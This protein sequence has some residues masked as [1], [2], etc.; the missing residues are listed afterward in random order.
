MPERFSRPKVSEPKF[1]RMMAP[2]TMSLR[3]T[4]CYTTPTQ[5]EAMRTCSQQ[6]PFDDEEDAN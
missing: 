2:P 1:E 3:Q 5:A 6:V 4:S